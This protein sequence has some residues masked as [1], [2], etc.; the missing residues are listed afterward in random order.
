[1]ILPVILQGDR[2]S[3]LCRSRAVDT[4]AWMPRCSHWWEQSCARDRRTR[5]RPL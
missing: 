1:M 4:V 5:P 2:W 3:G